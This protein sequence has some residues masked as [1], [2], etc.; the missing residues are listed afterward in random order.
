MSKKL[1]TTT[2]NMITMKHN[3][4]SLRVI[5][6]III[7]VLAPVH[8]VKA[9][10]KTETLMVQKKT[11]STS[12]KNNGPFV[13]KTKKKL[14]EFSELRIKLFNDPPLI[15]RNEIKL[16]PSTLHPGWF[17]LTDPIDFQFSLEL[18]FSHATVVDDFT[19]RS[20][21]ITAGEGMTRLIT[22]SLK[23]SINNIQNKDT[24]L[25]QQLDEIKK[26]S[27]EQG[28]TSSLPSQGIV[29]DI[30]YYRATTQLSGLPIDLTIAQFFLPQ[31]II[32]IGVTGTNVQPDLIEHIIQSVRIDGL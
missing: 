12:R 29:N 13:N 16:P 15:K 4:P 10:K 28:S 22:I 26:R 7:V 8:Q 6:L 21:E 24:F 27:I 30:P 18:P 3:T 5:F 20:T 31:T 32:Q 1:L 14:L 17:E 11:P 19:R 23:R 25:Q 9:W 2:W